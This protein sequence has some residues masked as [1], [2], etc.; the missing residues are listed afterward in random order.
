[1]KKAQYTIE[2]LIILAMGLCHALFR[3]R[4]PIQPYL[5]LILF[6]TCVGCIAI[7][8][9]HGG[10]KPRDFGLR[11]DNLTA[12]AV[13]TFWAF[14]FPMLGLI[15]YGMWHGVHLPSH[16]YYTLLLYP[17]WGMLQQLLF[18]GVFLENLTR[19]GLRT[20]AIPLSATFYSSVHWPSPFM[21]TVTFGGGL[22]LAWVYYYRR[23]I[24]PI[25]IAH[26]ILGALLYYVVLGKDPLAKWISP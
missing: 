15:G 18:Q 24:I 8:V 21:L 13:T 17:F 16:F 23:N 5:M 26:G 2:V 4:L 1:M 22:L 19:L 11:T 20:S 6:A 25:G 10:R 12:A 14:V 9:M 7:E 3:K